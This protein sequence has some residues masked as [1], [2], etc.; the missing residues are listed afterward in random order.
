MNSAFRAWLW[1]ATGSE[2]RA[3]SPMRPSPVRCAGRHGMTTSKAAC[4]L[5][6]LV[7]TAKHSFRIYG[8]SVRARLPDA[9]YA[10]RCRDVV[11]DA[12]LRWQSA[13]AEEVRSPKS[14]LTTIVRAAGARRIEGRA[15]AARNLRVRGCRSLWWNRWERNPWNGRIALAGFPAPCWNRSPRPSA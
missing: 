15:P 8:H 13:A 5:M 11:Q 1:P 10:R 4:S 3:C 14:Y 6:L 12:Y 2:R 9:R 7:W